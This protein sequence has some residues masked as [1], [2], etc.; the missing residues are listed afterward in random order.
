MFE[1]SDTPVLTVAEARARLSQML[2]T[3]RSD[4]S[5]RPVVI[6]SHRKPEAVLMPVGHRQ[7]AARDGVSLQRLT[8]LRSIIEKLARASKLT[9]VRVYGSVSRGTQTSSS[10]VDL[11]V[12]PQSGATLFDIAGFEI[13]MET[14]LGAPVSAVSASALDPVLDAEILDE[15]VPL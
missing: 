14:L 7:D 9:D 4:P 2:R 12:T 11:L 1:G 5:A 6:G 10:D 8:D 13:D 3:F 15:A